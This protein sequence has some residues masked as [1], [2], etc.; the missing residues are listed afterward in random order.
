[1]T[2]A[3]AS[4]RIAPPAP[5]LPKRRGAE[6]AMLAFVT[7]IVIAAQV[8]ADLA[9]SDSIDS[10]LLYYALGFMGV[11][12]VAHLAVRFTAPYA[13]PVLLPSVAL[14]NGL[15][16][17]MIR[18]LDHTEREYAKSEGLPDP[19]ATANSQIAWMILG[20]LLFIVVLA[21]Y[22][23]HRTLGRFT[24]TLGF[25][26]LLLLALPAVLP[27]VI[28]P[29]IN[30][31]KIWIRVA[32]FSLQPG[33]LAKVALL[34][35]FAGYLVAKR[36]VLSLASRK[37]LG[38]EFPRMRD[39]GP[40]VVIWIF[41]LLVLMF[42]KDLGSSLLF[43]GIF[44]AL[45][46]IATEKFSWVVIGLALFL[47]GATLAYQL[48]GHVQQRVTA[49][50]DPF[51]SGDA[52]YQL[53]QAMFGFGTG[54]MFGTGWGNGHPEKVPLPKS[55]FITAALG[56]ELGLVGIC[57]V[58]VLYVVIVER[59][60][61]TSLLVR[62]SFGTLLAAGLAFSIGLQ[63]FV[64][65]GGVTGLIPL[66]GLTTPFLSAGGSSLIANFA[67]IALLMRISD[68]ARRPA[69][70][71]KPAAA[72][73]EQT[74]QLA[75]VDAGKI[76]THR[77]QRARAAKRHLDAFAGDPSDELGA[78]AAAIG[79]AN[80][81]SAPQAVIDEATAITDAATQHA[82]ERAAADGQKPASERPGT[83]TRDEAATERPG[84]DARDEAAAERPGTDTRDEAAA[85]RPGARL[86]GSGGS[87][88]QAKEADVG[89]RGS[90]ADGGR[91]EGRSG[92]ANR[93]TDRAHN[94]HD[95]LPMTPGNWLDQRPRR[96]EDER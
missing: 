42:E 46:Y 66:T 29:T 27:S 44:V 83:D 43:F 1:M 16:L 79:A 86:D 45:L 24:F 69:V 84:A 62:D 5:E 77:Q 91:A 60:F 47:G 41:S 51:G 65:V 67:L 48:F 28:A 33:E 54:G 59:G 19:G 85:E 70:R 18:R 75:K 2:A 89:T 58:L 95:D 23:D 88:R 96:P 32:G 74:M 25:A 56:E 6:L 73:S 38:L 78:R 50:L 36:D 90:G 37:V 40:I 87:T 8:A 3:T 39:L 82:A 80:A 52:G 63:V 93:A 20:V 94:G 31:A 55:D 15:G 12:G 92:A 30:G 11:W 81:R 35:S 21:V 71:P 57:A 64:I 22:R 7:V 34:I 9:Q 10:Q 53:R 26:G 49:W 68:A 14:L 17:V 72:I 61:R 4:P 13:D 76:G